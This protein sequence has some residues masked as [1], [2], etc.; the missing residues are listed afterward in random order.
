MASR[1]T[2][3]QAEE[4]VVYEIKAMCQAAARY[5]EEWEAINQATPTGWEDEIFFL[6]AAL[7]HARTLVMAFGYPDSKAKNLVKALGVSDGYKKPFKQSFSDP[8]DP[9]ATSD[10]KYGQLSELLAHIGATRWNAPH[11]IKVHQPIEVAN[12][13]LDALQASGATNANAAVKTAV[14]EGRERM[15]QLRSKYRGQ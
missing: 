3:A 5:A 4:H 1:P 13:V 9:S 12:S 2:R 7:A 10:E 11:G 14:D 6:E 8:S 15:K